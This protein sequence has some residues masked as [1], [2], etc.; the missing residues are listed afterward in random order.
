MSRGSQILV[1]VDFSEH[2]R[3]AVE[4]AFLIAGLCEAQVR[5]LHALQLPPCT[6]DPEFSG[7][8][9][10]ELRNSEKR[11]F[12][13]YCESLRRR[14]FEFS[15]RF[16]ERDPADAIHAAARSDGTRLV[17]MGSHGRRGLDRL[18]L[19]SVAERTLQDAPVPVLIVRE[20][21]QEATTEIRSILFATD[22]SKDAERVEK[23]VGHW[24]GR[25]GAQVEVFHAIR[26]TAVLFAPY[27]VAGSSDFEGEMREAAM[28]RSERVLDRLTQA[29]VS[30]KSK[31]VYGRASDSILTRAES[32]GAQLIALG[33]SGYSAFQRFLLGSVAQRVSRHASCSV[34][35]AGADSRSSRI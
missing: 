12:E 5:L 7:A 1:P 18:I 26:E 32:T 35:V 20:A 21:E 11:E 8:L 17:V 2:S 3:A 15:E 6:L 27:A 33:T 22:F 14:G 28:R 13:E 9:R 23:I 16:E 34:L 19:G 25:L 31:I 10:D 24:A 30:C 4:R 29:G